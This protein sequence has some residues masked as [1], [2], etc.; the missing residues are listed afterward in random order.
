MMVHTRY[1]VLEVDTRQHLVQNT[2]W[3]I[4]IVSIYYQFKMASLKRELEKEV[5][6]NQENE[7]KIKRLERQQARYEKDI[8]YLYDVIE[9]LKSQKKHHKESCEEL[10]ARILDLSKR[11]NHSD[12]V[13]EEKE[14]FILFRESQLLELEDEIYKLKERIK[15]LTSLE[16]MASSSSSSTRVNLNRMTR[17]ELKELIIGNVNT[18]YNRIRI[19]RSEDDT[20]KN[21]TV[22]ALTILSNKYISDLHDFDEAR[23]RELAEEVARRNELYNR[24][25]RKRAKKRR[26][27]ALLETCNRMGGLL[28]VRYDRIVRALRIQNQ[29]LQIRL[30]NA[31]IN[32]LP[33]APPRLTWLLLH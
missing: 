33:P 28:K 6:I 5:A 27:K 18:L 22:E 29:V 23:R 9:K 2:P 31:P 25:L 16:T 4:A 17:D 26:L 32:P 21:R 7:A 12:R 1:L 13:C 3:L 30:N 8:Q 20:V 14:Q 11:L 15:T 10:K 24:F 19:R